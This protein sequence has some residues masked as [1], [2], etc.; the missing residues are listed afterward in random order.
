[1]RFGFY[2]KLA[3][4]GIRKN[5]RMYIPYLLTCTGMVMMTYIL[6][7]LQTAEPISMMP[8]GSTI[9]EMLSLGGWVIALFSAVFLF[10][11]NSFLLRRRKKEF[12]LYNILG[13]G[14]RNIGMIVLWEN[15]FVSVFSL[16]AG[17]L[18]GMV[19]SKLAEL[20]IVNIMG[21]GVTYDLSISM[22]G[23]VITARIFGVIFILLL[24]NALRQ[25]RFASAIN[26]LHSE[27]MGEKPPKANWFL[28]ILGVFV[29]GAA[30]YIAQVIEDPITALLWFFVAAI[31]VIIGTYLVM[32]SGSVL[33]CRILQKRKN[34]YYKPNHFVSVSSM[35]YRMKRNG[36]GLASICILA[37]MVLVMISSTSALFIGEEDILRN[38]FPGEIN[39]VTHLDN[40]EDF[41]RENIAVLR[42][43]I[44]SAAQEYGAAPENVIDYRSAY[45]GGLVMGNTVEVDQSKVND[46]AFDTFSDVFQIYFI[47]LEDYNSMMG[48]NTTLQEGEALVHTFRG[49]FREDT[50]SFNRGQSFVIKEH[51]DTCFT[52]GDMAMSIVPSMIIVVPDV[53]K[54]LEGLNYDNGE[55]MYHFR[56][57]Y[58]FDTQLD[59]ETEAALRAELKRNFAEA[60]IN[61]TRDF[62]SI[63]ITSREAERADF[64]GLYGGLFCLG[65]ILS[66]VFIFAAV[67]IIYYKQI[68]EGYEDSGRF[69]IMQKVGMTKKEIRKSINSQLLTVFFLPLAGAGLHLTFAF[70]IIEKLLL[71][72]NMKNHALFVGTT[73]GSF[74]VFA[75][76][77]IV[78]YRITSN[79]YYNIVSGA[80]EK[81]A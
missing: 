21:E 29:L 57:E 33:F 48:T 8:G 72:F 69:A 19:F 63:S 2:P 44:L 22:Q 24:L 30:Y 3:L 52:S 36:A 7:Y 74:L 55:R 54:A 12:G 13:M 53:P 67:L 46:F 43:D 42:N 16:A 11:T 70:S 71:M 17:L 62:A 50:I 14:K 20:I 66:L 28:G 75:V 18:S 58:Y 59:F 64:F 77:Y 78:V 47:P 6:V 60:E 76:F 15:V 4:D 26:L 23:I 38:R 80:K 61:N 9:Q 56:W 51:L 25:V 27:N 79:A 10:Y 1:M 31:M 34:Y 65:L 32:I 35:A 37:T 39:V 68:S 40:P 81:Q 5:K 49:E 73:I 41:S 45:I